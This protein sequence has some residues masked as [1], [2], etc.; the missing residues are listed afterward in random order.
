M[1]TRHAT[2]ASGGR[3]VRRA[4]VTD[5]RVAALRI[6]EELRSGSLLD[7]AFERYAAVLDSR[8]RRWLQQLVYGMLRT[9]SRLDAVIEAR[10]T[11]GIARLN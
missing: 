8:N 11:G 9:R 10:V 3:T 2:P 6:C 1:A 5:T 4:S 7:T